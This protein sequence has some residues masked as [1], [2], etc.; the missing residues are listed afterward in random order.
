MNEDE[1]QRERIEA[2]HE[3]ASLRCQGA[4]KL[5]QRDIVDMFYDDGLTAKEALEI[6]KVRP[7]GFLGKDILAVEKAVKAVI[8]DSKAYRGQLAHERCQA[9]EALPPIPEKTCGWCGVD[10]STVGDHKIVDREPMCN[11][12]VSQYFPEGIER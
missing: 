4:T 5:I 9:I 10:I 11:A 1:L 2:G 8:E 3:V 6:Q 12:C 7:I